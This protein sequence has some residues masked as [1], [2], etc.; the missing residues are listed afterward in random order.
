MGIGLSVATIFFLVYYYFDSLKEV[1]DFDCEVIATKN[2][3]ECLLK[4]L[5]RT[6][7]SGYLNFF[8]LKGKELCDKLDY[9]SSYEEL[10]NIRRQIDNLE[11]GILSQDFP[12][13]LPSYYSK[14]LSFKK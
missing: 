2:H 7:S 3:L 8:Y 4:Y 11:S 12:S 13:N 10:D 5:N 14:K 9:C 6:K 1:W